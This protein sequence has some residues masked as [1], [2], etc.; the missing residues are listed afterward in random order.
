MR[1]MQWLRIVRDI[2]WFDG[3]KRDHYNEAFEDTFAKQEFRVCIAPLE[4]S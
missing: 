1:P 3:S 4:E 2:Q